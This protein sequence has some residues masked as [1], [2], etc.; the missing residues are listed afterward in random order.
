LPDGKSLDVA[1]TVAALLGIP[2]PATA[3]G[4]TLVEAL[5]VDSSTRSRL[6]MIDQ[7]RIKRVMADLRSARDAFATRDQRARLIRALGALAFVALLFAVA[8]RFPSPARWGLAAGVS[9]M[10]S[11][12]L[13]HL[14]VWG[15][16]SFSASSKMGWVVAQS[17]ALSAGLSVV[18][19]GLGRR[20]ALSRPSAGDEIALGFA[21][22]A[23]AAPF[24][25][26]SFV[27]VG[28]FAPRLVCEPS[29]LAA[30]PMVAY[31]ALVPP[32][33]LG[34]GVSVPSM[35]RVLTGRLKTEP[36]TESM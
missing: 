20:G 36:V 16:V 1:P 8:R 29:W 33:L 21:F 26:A 25:I 30:A 35:V 9:T 31:A 3:E 12:L 19:L 7:S 32:A 4:H 14:V 28:A 24:A 22:A 27:A 15:P 17:A 10:L 11:T 6:E 34:F 23:G 18:L 5:D 2:A 13:F